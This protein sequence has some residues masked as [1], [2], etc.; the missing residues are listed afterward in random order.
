M[1]AVSPMRAPAHLSTLLPQ[2]TTVYLAQ[3]WPLLR[4]RRQ[5]FDENALL[6]ICL[7]AEWCAVCRDFKPEYSALAQQHPK[8]LFAYIDIEDDEALIG[9]LELDDFPTLVVF[10]GDALVHFGIVKAKRSNIVQLLQKLNASPPQPL[11][12]PPTLQTLCAAVT[13]H[14]IAAPTP[15]SRTASTR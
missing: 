5:A 9:A 2:N 11:S 13:G 1:T 4:Q 10:R 8:T 6:V 7:C 14:Q 12:P 15:D 3:H